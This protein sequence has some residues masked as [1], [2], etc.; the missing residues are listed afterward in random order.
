MSVSYRMFFVQVAHKKS[1][2][3]LY[4]LLLDSSAFTFS[5]GILPYSFWVGP[6]KKHPEDIKY[7]SKQSWKLYQSLNAGRSS[8]VR[9]RLRLLWQGGRFKT[10]HEF[11]I[12]SDAYFREG[13][14]SMHLGWNTNGESE[15]KGERHV[16]NC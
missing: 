16:E 13:I 4:N 8:K 7:T 3:K 5:V 10:H 12:R 1:K 15:A 6:V 14:L 9:G 11:T 2:V